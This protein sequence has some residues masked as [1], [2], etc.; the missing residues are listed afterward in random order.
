M[1]MYKFDL[2]LSAWV[3]GIEIEAESEEVARDTLNRMSAEEI[4]EQGYVNE[5]D[6]SNVDCESDEDDEI[7]DDEEDLDY[8]E[9][10]DDEDE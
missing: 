9:Y 2:N 4:I 5:Y 8:E 3:Q 7:F 6:I 10:Y 1:P